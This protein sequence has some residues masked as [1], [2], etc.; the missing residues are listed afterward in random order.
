MARHPLPQ[1]L[2]GFAEW[3]SPYDVALCDI[4]GVLHDGVK[5]HAGAG[6][7]LTRFR[8]RGGTVVLVSNAPRPGPS[9][10]EILDGMGVARSA[11]DGIVTSGDVTRSQLEAEPERPYHWLGPERD[12]PLF[13]GLSAASVPLREAR[14]VVCTGLVN[15]DRETPEDYRTVLR[16][17]LA[18]RLP[19]LCANPDL[20]VERG[21]ELIYCAG[22]LAELYGEMGGEVRMAG[23]PYAAIYAAALEVAEGIRRAGTPLSKVMAIGDA[24]RTDVAGAVALGCASLFVARGIHT[25]ELGLAENGLTAA[26]LQTLLMPPAPVPTAVIDKLV[27]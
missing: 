15:D 7:A 2:E 27:W 21:D 18:L 23:K 8:A 5:A 3:S 12:W 14:I 22:A 11:Y 24:L 6:D 16:E 10:I 26:A 1:L 9:V 20:V 4:W 25:R 19:M 17:A 13:H